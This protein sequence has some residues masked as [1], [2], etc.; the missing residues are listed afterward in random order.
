MPSAINYI[1]PTDAERSEFNGT[2][3]E[4][5]SIRRESYATALRYYLGD[6]DKPDEDAK[7]ITY[8]NMVKMT[9]ERTSS[10]L[11]PQLPKFETDPA[12][13]EPT[14]EEAYIRQT[15][16]V[17]GGL[18]LLVK[19]AERGF[20]AG[21]CFV[22]V[23]PNAA[24]LKGSTKTFPKINLLDPVSVNVYWKADDVSD[25]LWYEQR[26]FVGNTAY[27]KDYV[28]RGDFWQVFSYKSEPQGADLNE[29]MVQVMT[30]HGI[31]NL[32]QFQGLPTFGGSWTVAANP[33]DHKTSVPPIIEWAHLPHPNDYFGLTEFGTLKSLQDSINAV[34]SERMRIIRQ[35]AEPVDVVTGAEV[36]EINDEGSTISIPNANARI[37]RLEFK[38]DMTSMTGVLDKLVETYL[39]ISRV[40]LLK[41]EAKDLQRVTNASV[42]TL[43]IDALAKNSV[44]QGSYGAGLADISKLV[45]LMGY[46]DK[47]V[48]KNPADMDVQIKFAMALPQDM[49]EIV[50]VNTIAIHDGYMSERTAATNLGLDFAFEKAA[51]AGEKQEAEMALRQKESEAKVAAGAAK[52]DS[53]KQEQPDNE[54][55]A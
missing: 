29:N 43:F 2:V 49:T 41:G 30:T 11:F 36:G 32:A 33:E 4:E 27:I 18:P 55:P 5:T 22:Y 44:L 14:P 24:R 34:A 23:K 26:Y 13:V 28:N 45:L 12:S 9:A 6:H 40:V 21:H 20:L 50:N 47:K 15:F 48:T 37:T 53:S 52:A 16:M 19:M 42:R 1:P 7:D 31:P 39:S 35:H 46:A 38:G 8:I 10:F 54:N 17:N 25:V 3:T 51:G